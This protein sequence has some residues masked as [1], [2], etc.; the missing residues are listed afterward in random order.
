M[1]LNIDLEPEIQQSL[2]IEANRK[3]LEVEKLAAQ[4]VADGLKP[5][6]TRSH[7]RRLELIHKSRIS[8]LS[9]KEQTELDA[10]QLDADRR[11]EQLDRERLDEVRRMEAEV[12]AIVGAGD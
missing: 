6:G 10:L 2:E 11:L 8:Q 3:G 9:P 7:D 1:T 4:L 12:E 5:I